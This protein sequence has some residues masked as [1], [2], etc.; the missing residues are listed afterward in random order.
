M[1]LQFK[2]ATSNFLFLRLQSSVITATSAAAL[3]IPGLAG[4]GSYWMVNT[5]FC[6]ALGVAIEGLILV[7]YIN[8][9]SGGASDE[10]LGKLA[11]GEMKLFGIPISPKIPALIMGLPVVFATYSSLFL[12]VGTIAMVMTDP[13]SSKE[14]LPNPYYFLPLV[15]IGFGFLCMCLTVIVCEAGSYQEAQ[16]R[17]RNADR[18]RARQKH[19][20]GQALPM[21]LV[22]TA[23]L[24]E[25]APLLRGAIDQGTIRSYSERK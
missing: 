17:R 2:S 8:V 1:S 22:V 12:L 4:P 14:N 11:R 20:L 3:A 7:F 16:I 15:P 25:R 10:T 19:L 18:W 9:M 13:R 5:C 23:L 24:P 21:S 6:I